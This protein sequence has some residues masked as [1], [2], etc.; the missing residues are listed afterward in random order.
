MQE[1]EHQRQNRRLARYARLRAI[2]QTGLAY[3]EDVFGRERYE[4]LFALAQE[5]QA[6][7]TGV[8]PAILETAFDAHVGYPT[9]KVEVRGAVFSD[10][11]ILLVRESTDNRWALPGGWCDQHISPGGNVVKEV[12][13][14]TGLVVTAHKLAAV[15]DEAVHTYRPKRLEHVYKLL[16][17]CEFVSGELTTSIETTEAAYFAVDD[18]PE[19]SL[20]RT[21][22]EDILMLAQHRVDRRLTT[23]FD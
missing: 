22:P 8:A 15:R 7:A 21:L 12:F 16:F 18:L 13:E 14:E 23:E 2:A 20:G 11:R 1:D 4:E 9:P 5:L 19:L 6:E 3:T 17:L 10:D